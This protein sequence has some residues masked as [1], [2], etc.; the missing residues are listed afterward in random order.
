MSQRP[1]S[2]AEDDYRETRGKATRGVRN[3]MIRHVAIA[4][5]SL[6]GTTV[7]AREVGPA[8]WGGFAIAY[9]LLVSVDSLLSRSLIVG[10]VRR[11]VA[12]EPA[13]VR[14][15]ARLVALSGLGCGIALVG[16]AVAVSPWYS[17]PAFLPIMLATG[18][19]CVLFGARALSVVLMERDLDYA[20]IARMEIADMVAFYGV[21]IPVALA[22]FPL[23]A[24]VA[25]TLARGLAS[26]ATA[27]LR[28]RSPVW[29]ESIR[30]ARDGLLPFG[31]PL[32]L[33]FGVSTIDGLVPLALLGS[34]EAE[35]GFFVL[36]GQLAGYAL[37][38]VSSIN[39]VGLP[40]LSRL[41][42][43]P[44]RHAVRR[45]TELATFVN[46]GIIVPLGALSALWY[47]LLFGERF[48]DGVA[49]FQ[50]IA[51]GTLLAGP[52]GVW[53]AALPASGRSGSLLATQVATT[54]VYVAAGVGLVVAVGP[55]GAAIAYVASRAAGLVITGAVLHRATG[56]TVSPLTI[57]LLLAAAA[58][59]G[60]I[61]AAVE[62]SALAG[63]VCLVVVSV[64]WLTAFRRLTVE[65]VHAVLMRLPDPAMAVNGQAGAP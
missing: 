56:V 45:A 55:L 8:A 33:G 65:T 18:G 21:A 23:E 7:L 43:E 27:R 2:D 35:V 32:A 5:I 60:A 48:D 39:R 11:Q 54:G 58:G 12:A 62:L 59:F 37:T 47:P 29:G 64:A 3:L 53:G 4:V 10:L 38:I 41:D 16:F 30:P 51:L 20:G 14:S 57:V 50:L 24:L 36:A 15:A 25:G 9:L 6:G 63:V 52:V 26:F 17:P 34:N 49:F 22:G 40:S 61:Y 1:I 44:F 42:P 31:L 46:A 28:R 13:M 19:A